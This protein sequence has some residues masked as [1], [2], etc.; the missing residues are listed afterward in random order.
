MLLHG[1][2]GGTLVNGGA[3]IGHVSYQ[4]SMFV[5]ELSSPFLFSTRQITTIS[6]KVLP[7]KPCMNER[8]SDTLSGVI[9]V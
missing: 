9:R 4:P 5:R 7:E 6:L 3:I 1:I 8:I 2:G